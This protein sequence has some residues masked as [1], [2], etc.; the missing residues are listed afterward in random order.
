MAYK[1]G[2]VGVFSGKKSFEIG[3]EARKDSMTERR[4]GKKRTD[5]FRLN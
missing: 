4:K 1:V 5:L 2:N 3:G